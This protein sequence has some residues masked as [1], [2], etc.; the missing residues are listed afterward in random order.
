MN[1]SAKF[2]SF[3]STNQTEQVYGIFNLLFLQ[4]LCIKEKQIDGNWIENT[5]NQINNR[6][7]CVVGN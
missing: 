3:S 7:V 4:F 5:Q 1:V 6:T 2:N